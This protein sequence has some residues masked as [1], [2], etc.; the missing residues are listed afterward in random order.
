MRGPGAVPGLYA[1]E[2]AMNELAIQLKIDPVQLRLLNEPKIDESLQLPF[3]SRHL[4]R[5][6]RRGRRKFRLVGAHR[7][8]RLHAQTRRPRP[9]LGRGGCA[10]PAARCAA[11]QPFRL[12]DDGT[13]R[14]ACATQDIGTGTYTVLAQ[15]AADKTGLP[16]HKIDVVLGNSSLPPGPTSGGSMVTGT[17]I[18]AVFQAAD[19]ATQQLLT[20]AATANGTPFAQR[21]PDELALKAGRIHIKTDPASLAVPFETFCSTP[22]SAPPKAT[23]TPAPSSEDPTAHKYSFHSWGAHFLEVEWDPGIARLRVNRVVTVIDGGQM[24]NPARRAQPDRRRH[25]DGRR[26]GHARTHHLRPAQG[27]PVNCNLADYMSP[28]TPTPRDRRPLPRLS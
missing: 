9:R 26:H 20:A 28:P 16:L 23:A 8:S 1:T 11:K 25:R 4:P 17:V 13:A 15:L 2:S 21:K 18:P 10:W 5:M 7:R 27:R 19:A 6:P 14:V 22:T 12:R 3:S 24:I